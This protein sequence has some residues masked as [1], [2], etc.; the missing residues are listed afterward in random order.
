MGRGK[1]RTEP[2]PEPEMDF[3]YALLELHSQTYDFFVKNHPDHDITKAWFVWF[4][5]PDEAE[6]EFIKCCSALS[7]PK[8]RNP[9]RK[10]KK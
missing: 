8:R 4:K 6:E 1:K 5:G 7:K 10:N 3:G 9:S 2:E